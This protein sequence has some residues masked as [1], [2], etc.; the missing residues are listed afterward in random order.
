[1]LFGNYY[2]FSLYAW[3]QPNKLKFLSEILLQC[4][5][6]WTKKIQRQLE[7]FEFQEFSEFGNFINFWIFKESWEIFEILTLC[8]NL[9]DSAQRCLNN[10]MNFPTN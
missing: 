2:V 9:N 8:Y 4:R 10:I 5:P 1:M 6:H 3:L 7:I